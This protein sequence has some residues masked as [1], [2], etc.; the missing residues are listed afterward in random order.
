VWQAVLAI[1]ATAF[2]NALGNWFS[3]RENDTTL[4][5]L[6]RSEA[7]AETQTTVGAVADDQAKNNAQVRTASSVAGNLL[8]DAG[9]S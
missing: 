1:I 4:K 3:K 6:G 7:A 2:F 5:E 8:R 9:P